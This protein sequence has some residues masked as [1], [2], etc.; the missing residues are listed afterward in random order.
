MSF[1]FEGDILDAEFVDRPN[2]FLVR[3]MLGGRLIRAYMPNP[4]RMHELLF[5]GS[6]LYITPSQPSMRGGRKTQFTVVAVI[7]ENGGVIFL[8]THLTNSIAGSL[9]AAEA[10]PSLAQAHIV[11]AEVR[12]GRSR[13]DFVLEEEGGLVYMEVKSCTMFGNRIAM[14]PDAVTERGRRH[15]VELADMERQPIALFVVHSPHV[16]W[17]MPDYHTDL[18]FSRTMLSVRDRLRIIPVSIAWRRNLT[19]EPQA[20][21]LEIPWTYLEREV[22]DRGA[23]LLILRLRRPRVVT[24]GSLGRILFE[25]GHYVYVG[26]ATVNLSARLAHHGRIRKTLRWHVDYLRQVADE[27]L[28]LPVRS[29][30]RLECDLAAACAGVMSTGPARFGSSDCTCASHLFHTP[31]DPLDNRQF[32]KLLQQFRMAHPM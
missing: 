1:A 32:H 12:H 21:E 27:V 26:S 13:F 30:R 6:E 9:I 4:G 22:D 7:D 11:G 10:V 17:F 20:R 5:P 15:L 31:S 19:I 29:S 2:R 16:D 8:H 14:F 28:P 23:Y 3:C 24:V 25:P 18:E